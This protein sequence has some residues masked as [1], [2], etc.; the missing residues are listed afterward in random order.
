[1]KE[2]GYELHLFVCT[3]QR[4]GKA[5]CSDH[6]PEDLIQKLKNECKE[7]FGLKVRINKSG[8]LSYCA[9]GGVAVLYPEGKWYTNI[10]E[11]RYD[12]LLADIE[13]KLKLE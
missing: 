10:N 12:E 7:R 5:S 8:C 3:N 11:T 1:M 4:E 9:K 13:R 2:L 6:G